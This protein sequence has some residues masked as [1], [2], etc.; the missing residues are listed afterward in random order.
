M[1]EANP[2][3]PSEFVTQIMTPDHNVKDKH[4]KITM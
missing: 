4:E 2:V 1:A 3:Q